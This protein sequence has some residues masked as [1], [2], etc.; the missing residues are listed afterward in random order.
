MGQAIPKPSEFEEEKVNTRI[1]RT[2]DKD[3]QYVTFKCNHRRGSKKESKTK[4]DVK[5]MSK[6]VTEQAEIYICNI[7]TNPDD[8]VAHLCSGISRT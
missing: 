8:T 7:Y 3:T 5:E 6:K 1:R 4:I 2:N